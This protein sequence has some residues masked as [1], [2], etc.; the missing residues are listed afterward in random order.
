MNYFINISFFLILI[1]SFTI[2]NAQEYDD[3]VSDGWRLLYAADTG[4]EK[5]VRWLIE[6]GVDPDFK[7]YEGV[8][9]LMLASQA[10]FENIVR[11]LL[12]HGADVNLSSDYYRV[13]PLISAV[14]NDYLRVAELLLRNGAEINHDDNWGRKAIH[15]AVMNNY[16]ATTDMLIYYNADIDHKDAYGLTPLMYAVFYKN[17]TIT[18]MLISNQANIFEIADDKNSILHLAA[19]S[20]NMF[21]TEKYHSYFNP[22]YINSDSLTV[23]EYSVLNGNSEVLKF[24]LE[25]GHEL[26]DTINEVYTPLSIAKYSRSFKT[27]RMVKKLGYRNLHYPYFG[28]LGFGYEF[29]FNSTDFFMGANLNVTED[30][31]GFVLAT[32]FMFRGAKKAILQQKNQLDFYQL[33]ESRYA[34]YFKLQKHFKIIRFSDNSNL[35]IFAQIRPVYSWGNYAGLEDKMSP[36][37]F[38]VPGA[39]LSLNL[40]RYFRLNFN[41]EYCDMNIYSVNPHMY[42]LGLK[43]IFPYRNEKN[44]EKY[45][46]IIAH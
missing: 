42:N 40:S 44:N 34:F 37:I 36:E 5:T 25:V 41:Y 15:Y 4:D 12:R 2:L 22:Y 38:P 33:F 26:R 21:F 14:R 28:R 20:G 13:S 11:I 10:G 7:N 35:S 30:R 23:V 31:Y 18:E 1:C 46:Y 16:I 24:L 29:L 17:D 32:G 6:E 9:A 3:Y 43:L 8:T 19:Q 39:G 27:K 45:K